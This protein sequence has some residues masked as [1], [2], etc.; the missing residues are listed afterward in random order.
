MGQQNRKHA[1]VVGG[2]IGGLVAA[3]VLCDHFDQVTMIDRDVFPEIG[4]QRRGVPQGVHTHG[5]LASGRRVLE[6]LFPG[7]SDE[8][9][10]CGVPAG[11]VLADSR[12]FF[13]G[14]CLSRCASGLDALLLSR[15]LLEGVVRKRLLA[16]PSIKTME[17]R[18]VEG[19]AASSDNRRVTGVRV[20]A[21]ADKQAQGETI[22][23]DLVID[24]TGR[25]SHSPAWLES[26]GFRKPNE[27]KVE[28]DIA[29]TTR[30]FRRRRDH[31][32]GD[33]AVVIQPTPEAKRRGVLLAQEGDRWT[34]T[35]VGHSGQVAPGELAGFIEFA[36]TLP[37]PFIHEVISNAEPIGDAFT[38]RFPASVRRRYEKLK[39]FPGGYLVFGDASVASIHPTDRACPSPRSSPRPCSSA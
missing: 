29:Y 13:E 37:A 21:S 6:S 30:L 27:E 17:N 8:L 19:L 7:I 26:I 9:I 39:S 31:L 3:R 4:R 14:A 34:A 23:A 33:S 2:G 28:V 5:L 12:W 11:D 36:R 35:L 32:N 38:G 25:S 20:Q 10:E 24:S 16:I 22:L 15:P 1:I 18:V